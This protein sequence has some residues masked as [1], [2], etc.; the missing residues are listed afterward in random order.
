M[1]STASFRYQIVVSIVLIFG[2]QAAPAETGRNSPLLRRA[3][4]L[5]DLDNWA[6]AE[7]EFAKAAVAFRAHAD[8]IG[9]EYAE[10]GIIRG[11]IQRRNLALTSA[12]LRHRLESDPLMKSDRDL[13][14]FCLAMKGEIDGEM[15][16]AAMRRD[17]EEVS[18]LARDSS[19]SRW[20]Y[21]ASAELGMAA[22]YEGDLQAA[23]E[24]IGAA[25]IA[26][27]KAHDIG[28]QIKYL[29]AIG[30]GLNQ[31]EMHTEAIQYLD[32]AIAL[33]KATPGAPYPFMPLLE[34][35]Q[36]LASTGQIQQAK[37]TVQTIL[38]SA[39]R[40]K[41]DEY[42]SITLAV[43]G[44]FQ[45][46]QG[47]AKGAIQT[48]S[49][50][51]AICERRGFERALGESRIALANIYSSQGQLGEAEQLLSAAAAAS[52]RNGELYTLPQR[53]GTL[54]G[55]QVRE[56]KFAEADHT[57]DRAA[58]FID[59]SI[60]NDPA[61]LDKTALI[62][63]ASDLYVAHFRLLTEH[64][65]NPVKAYSVVEQVRG[66]ILTDVLL[67]GSRTS[68]KAEENERAMSRFR[69]Q[70]TNA[71]STSDVERI[72]D[73]IAML[74]QSR[75]ITPD[76]SILKSRRYSHVMLRQVQHAL[77]SHAVIL[78]YVLDDP[79][80]WCLV[81]SRDSIH[82]V[83]LVSKKTFDAKV[84]AYLHSVKQKQPCQSA[85]R[86]LYDLLVK[87]AGAAVAVRDLL[88]V[89]DGI[90]NLVPFDALQDHAGRYA[91]EDTT[92]SYLPSAGSFYLLSE[93][94][95]TVEINRS[96]LAFGGIPYQDDASRFRKLLIVAGFGPMPLPNLRNS[97]EEVMMATDA[98]TGGE[99]T[100]V[101]G[102]KATETEFKKD[103]DRPHRIIHLAVH[104]V[105]D[106]DRPDRAALILAADPTKG[107]DGLLQAPEIAQLRIRANLIV[108]SACD[109]AVGP[110]E[111]QDGVATLARSFLLAG[112]KNVISTLWAADDNSSLA[113]MRGFYERI[114]RGEPPA[115]ALAD[116][117]REFIREFGD[118]SAPYYWAA[119]TF[120]GVPEAAISNEQN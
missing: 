75:W 42:E 17:W 44:Q 5:S 40:T 35:A 114:G 107:E 120:E 48:I 55:V 36:A 60:G 43:A 21:R 4:Q 26:A 99:R 12:Q 119:F 58:A 49:Q 47:D 30:V 66:R 100:V 101:V 39:R 10:L 117:K 83:R 8:K 105:T 13:R 76:V 62:K 3:F 87:P 90:L 109:T 111:G 28:S 14:I 41:A 9:L 34:K 52:Q 73:R 11:T 6:E 95:R 71:A 92:I 116:A 56:G 112:A 63:S 68:L 106:A 77:N 94:A 50:A 61:V 32:K 37:T 16:A 103:I 7:P 81:I 113:L 118:G 45:A 84:S 15:G 57:Y 1:R 53:L 29:Y 108:L 80:S 24:K 67:G 19:D 110:V 74:E 115:S 27:T 59:A 33:A 97:R 89:R 23:R 96:V 69:L 20:Q 54:A 88:I 2:L 51:I 98:S 25:L 104:T 78:E 64:L 86:G 18:H 38:E 65:H 70:L 85:A 46:Q 22:Y 82:V 102:A 93:Q 72:R 31:T 79:A 91:G